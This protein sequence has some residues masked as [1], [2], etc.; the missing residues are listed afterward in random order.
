MTENL[1]D[2]ELKTALNSRVGINQYHFAVQIL[3]W[4]GIF[5][6]CFIFA[7]TLSGGIIIAYYQS[8][9]MKLIAAKVYDLNTLR[10]AQMIASLISFLLPALI[11]SK[12]K[13]QS[14]TKYANANTGFS[15]L[16]IILIPLLIV[17]VY[18]LINTSFFINK[19]FGLNE[20]MKSTQDEYKMLVDA[21]LKDSSVFVL[22]L[23][24]ITVAILPAIAEEWIFRGTF[25]KLLSEKLNIH[26]AVFLAS[27]IFSIVH[28][29]FSGFIPRI[30]LGMFLGYLFYYSGSLWASIF[31]HAVNNGSQV[32]FMY[33]NNKG[34]YKVDIENPEIPKTWEIIV[35]TAAFAGLW[36]LFYHFAQKRKNST[37]A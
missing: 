31:A 29:E 2:D 19:W 23:N 26:V 12:L 28:M 24:I 4:F 18:P 9:D 33:L 27:V 17:S 7:Q 34:I 11:F 10:Y 3:I 14:Y 8:T 6:G 5:L 1:L 13:S 32:V 36:Y 25:Q 20:I 22:I 35:Y 15:V 30:I 21:L 16:F 37:F